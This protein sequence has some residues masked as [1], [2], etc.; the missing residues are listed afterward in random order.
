MR[1]RTYSHMVFMQVHGSYLI[2]WKPIG[3]FINLNDYS[4]N[5]WCGYKMYK[6]KSIYVYVTERGISGTVSS[7]GRL[8]LQFLL[9]SHRI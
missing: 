3:L 1:K 8:K 5:L 2:T 6:E 4:R 9:V 7:I